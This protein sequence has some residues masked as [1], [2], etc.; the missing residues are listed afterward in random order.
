MSNVT[1]VMDTSLEE[2]LKKLEEIILGYGQMIVA[3]S[4]GVDSTFL[5]AFA[6]KVFREAG[7]PDNVAAMTLNLR[8]ASVTACPSATRRWTYPMC[9]MSLEIIRRTDAITARG[10]F[11]ERSKSGQT[12]SEVSLPTERIWMI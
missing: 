5:L 4:G 11:S 8:N 2:K 7:C 3:F 9:S 12:W 10:R 1:D 6:L